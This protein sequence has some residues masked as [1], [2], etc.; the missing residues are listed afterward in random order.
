MSFPLLLKESFAMTDRPEKAPSPGQ[1]I[2][3]ETI[4]GSPDKLEKL[5]RRAERVLSSLSCGINGSRDAV[6]SAVR[7]T[8]RHQDPSQKSSKHYPRCE[9]DPLIVSENQVWAYVG[10]HLK[11]KLETAKAQPRQRKNQASRASDQATE[12]SE[13]Y[14]LEQFLDHRAERQYDDPEVIQSY[15]DDGFVALREILGDGCVDEVTRDPNL[16]KAARLMM[17][18][19]TRRE[20]AAEMEISFHY[21]R[22]YCDKV[23]AVLRKGT[24]D[25]DDNGK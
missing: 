20:I 2:I 21:A 6:Q 15:I 9:R 7:T 14:W 25:G 11:R 16:E 13:S 24:Y 8:L 23:L 18:G 10:K 19:H 5:V 1:K 3:Q 17:V 22:K 12:A 4:N